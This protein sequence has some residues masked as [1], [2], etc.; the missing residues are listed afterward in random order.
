MFIVRTL[1]RKSLDTSAWGR[2][3]RIGVLHLSAVSIDGDGNCVHTRTHAPR[4]TPRH[5][6]TNIQRPVYKADRR[7]HEECKRREVHIY[8][9]KQTS[10]HPHVS[11]NMFFYTHSFGVLVEDPSDEMY[12]AALRG[13]FII[14]PSGKIR[15]IQINDDHV[16]RSVSETIRQI[17]VRTLH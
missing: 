5:P 1:L 2:K 3:G 6:D 14:D 7:R 12:G 4:H 11:I 13:L 8:T 15:S 10:R 16:G 17:K 9:D